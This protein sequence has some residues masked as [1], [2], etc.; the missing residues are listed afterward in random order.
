MPSATDPRTLATQ[1]FDAAIRNHDQV[2]RERGLDVWVGNEPTFTRRESHAPEWMTGA[3]GGDKS[4]RAI[5]LLVQ[6][7]RENPDF[8]VLRCIGRS[9]NGE[10]EARFSFGL[11]G[12]RDGAAIYRGPADPWVVGDHNPVTCEVFHSQLE[13]AF[14]VREWNCRAFQTTS[15]FRL[16][17]TQEA[18]QSLP[19]PSEDSRLERASIHADHKSA[20]AQ[21]SLAGDGLGLLIVRSE[22]DG[23]LSVELPLV[24]EVAVF[25]ALVGA[26]G[27]AALAASLPALILR[28]FPP[29]VNAEVSFLTVTPDPAV[30]EVNM[31]PAQDASEFLASNRVVY[32]AARGAGLSP[33]RLRYNGAI[34]D[35]GGGGQ[36]TFGGPSPTMSPFFVAPHALPRLLRYAL[37]HPALSYL[38]AH[39]YVGPSGQSV[40]PDEHSQD[41]LAELHLA[42]ALLEAQTGADPATLWRSLAPCLTDPTGNS[43]RA[44][45]NVEKLWN[46]AEPGRGQLGLV[47]FRALRMQDT[48]ERAAALVALL[49]AI[50]G[51]LMTRDVRSTGKDHGASLHDRFALPFYLEL[52][53]QE[54]LHDLAVAG[55]GLE[56]PV[57]LE[58]ARDAFR[59]SVTLEFEG[60]ELQLRQAVEFWPLLGDAAL[61]QG[62]SRLVDSST[63][64]LELLLRTGRNAGA[65]E[66]DGWQ[67]RVQGRAAPLRPESGLAGP[68][69]VCG[70]RYRS[71]LPA[72]GLHPLLGTQSP[73]NLTL[74]HP[75][76][77]Q[78]LE[79]TL[80]DWKPNGGVYAE[81]PQDL[82]DAEVRRLERCTQRRVP[83]SSLSA[84][85]P[86]HPLSVTPH[87]LDLRYPAGTTAPLDAGSAD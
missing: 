35:S 76:L 71:F 77:D 13:L 58:L 26:I 64:R 53:L 52:D 12:R 17:F 66:L 3:V 79:V 2:L 29:P 73:L 83:V 38:F 20:P 31:P 1:A 61:Q 45:L 63:A 69:R 84:A 36:I 6:L 25:E 85:V 7:A 33:Y 11:Y 65:E 24:A 34:A 39:D 46:P 67:L 50:V 21:D 41:T 54:V 82:A 56:E 43:H 68:V 57:R 59:P 18:G 81:L 80:H 74:S 60:V 42:I 48:P 72:P 4:E 15:D 19:E 70:V 44:E 47:E 49:R 86:I 22:S 5:Q 32:A 16:V 8:L 78:A 75:Q 9:Y 27:E 37:R 30:V 28:G 40:R 62:T 23:T 87:T 51:M 14:Q 10:P 55:F